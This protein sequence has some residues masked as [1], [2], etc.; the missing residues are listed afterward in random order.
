[1][2]HRSKITNTPKRTGAL[3]SKFALTVEKGNINRLSNSVL[4]LDDKTLNLLKQKQP[5]SLKLIEESILRSEK[6]SVNPVIFEDVN[7]ENIEIAAVK[8][9]GGEVNLR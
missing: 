8:T 6:P 1:M 5:K 4:S 3:S 2:Q 9:K 7:A